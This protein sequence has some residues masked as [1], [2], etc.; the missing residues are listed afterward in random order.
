MDVNSYECRHIE[1]P[2]ECYE[3][4]GI[5]EALKIVYFDGVSIALDPTNKYKL[6]KIKTK[7]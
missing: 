6:L 2:P 4:T 3:R 1:R 5:W 7:K